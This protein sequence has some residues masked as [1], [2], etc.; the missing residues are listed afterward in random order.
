MAGGQRQSGVT[1]RQDL[2]ELAYEIQFEDIQL[3]GEKIA[4]IVPVAKETGKYPVLPRE[5]KMKVPDTRRETDGGYGRD[6]WDW[7][8]E[9]YTTDEYGWE[10]PIDHVDALRD[11]DYIDHEEEATKMAYEKLLLARESRIAAAV[12]NTTVWT[13]STNTTAITNEWDDAANATPW[14]DIDTAAKVIRGKCGFSKGMFDLVLTDDLVEYAVRTNEVKGFFQY[15]GEYATLL[16]NGIQYQADFLASYFG[17][18]SVIVTATLYD[19]NKL[20]KETT[21]G[22][23]WSNEYAFLGK[24]CPPGSSL[25]TEG[26]F[27]QLIWNKY[28]SNFIMEDYEEPSKNKMYIRAREYWGSKSKTDY[29]HLLS[30]MKT[31]VSNGI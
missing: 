3:A 5:A 28:S 31:T 20:S 7:G 6:Q 10:E 12:Q 26:C 27:K 19:V 13:G 15:S 29:G 8:T 1:I 18:K 25:K 2:T 24:M 11:E 21:I 30:N 9:T 14:S 16:K 22:K 23:F 4:P 17:I